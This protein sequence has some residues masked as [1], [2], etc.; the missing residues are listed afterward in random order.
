[1]VIFP[2]PAVQTC[3]VH[4]NT[5]ESLRSQVCKSIRNKAYFPSNDAAIKLI[6]RSLRQIEGK[7]QP[8]PNEWHA[9][10]SILPI[11]FGERFILT[12]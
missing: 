9:A 11:Q 4:T 1:M 2:D 6:Y 10:K 12:E 7:W 5:I 8:P 3:I